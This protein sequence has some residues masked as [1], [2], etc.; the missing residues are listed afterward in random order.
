[1]IVNN[2]RIQIIF[3]KLLGD[4]F[5]QNQP[6]KIRIFQNPMKMVQLSPTWPKASIEW[7]GLGLLEGFNDPIMGHN[8]TWKVGSN[9]QIL[10][11]S[12]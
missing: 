12:F 6:K 4:D 8:L 1:M 11:E 9:N 5:L 2:D 10:D 3:W 7:S